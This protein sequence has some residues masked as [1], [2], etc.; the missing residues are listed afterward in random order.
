VY[1]LLEYVP[2][3]LF[4]DLIQASNGLGELGGR[5]FMEQLRDVIG[6]MQSKDVAHRDL[7]L[8]NI[9]IDD[10]LNLV[11]GDFGFATF[12]HVHQLSSYRGTKTYM[13]PEIKAGKT[14]DGKQTDMFSLGVIL[15]IIVQC[16]FPFAE[17]RSDDYYYNLLLTGDL[18]KYW[19]KT[20]GSALSPEFKDL[21]LR[22]LSHDPSKRITIE[23][24][25]Q[26]PWMQKPFNI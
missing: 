9:M 13:A 2:C 25:K 12:K 23:E 8:E 24:L 22:M 5:Y 16:L 3:G 11:I 21:V 19:A 4:F 15:F 10:K 14:Y 1:I 18:E 20:N 26:H 7:K 17:A 6:Y